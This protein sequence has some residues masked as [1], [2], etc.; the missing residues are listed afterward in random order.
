M[1]HPWLTEKW[2]G[3]FDTAPIPP[4][5]YDAMLSI[6]V[7]E[8]V[9]NP[10]TF[11]EAIWRG[12]KPGGAFYALTPHRLHPFAYAVLLVQAMNLK[13]KAADAAAGSTKINRYPAYYRVNCRKDV[14]RAAEGMDF[15]SAEFHYHPQT[16]WAQYFPRM[17]R[18]VPWM[19][20][21]LIGVRFL[22]CSQQFM[23]RLEK[24]GVWDGLPNGEAKTS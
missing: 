7:V 24:N 9:Q 3:E 21:F 15:E 2:C 14:A 6:N 13:D 22:A 16:Q 12:L 1:N 4:N 8:H 10:R 19:Y 17:L 23:F 18:F 11:L 20:D 5:T